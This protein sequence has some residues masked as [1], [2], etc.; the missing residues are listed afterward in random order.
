MSC[1]LVDAHRATQNNQ[2]KIS[3]Q[4]RFNIRMAS[5]IDVSKPKPRGLQ[6]GQKS[7]E[8]L[9]GNMLKDHDFAHD[10]SII[11]LAFADCRAFEQVFVGRKELGRYTHIVSAESDGVEFGDLRFITRYANGKAMA[12]TVT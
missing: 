12:L 4:R 9:M 5:K 2:A 11:L 10:P 3:V 8:G 6:H 7:A 1:A